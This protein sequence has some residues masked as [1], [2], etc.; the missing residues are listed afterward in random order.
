MNRQMQMYRLKSRSRAVR[1]NRTIEKP[2]REACS[3]NIY[4]RIGALRRK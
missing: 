4:L 3:R 1:E 2:A